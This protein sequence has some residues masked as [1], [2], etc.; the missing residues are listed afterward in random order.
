MY[1]LSP[2]AVLGIVL[3][4]SHCPL[5][6]RCEVK[7]EFL[8]LRW[9]R[10][11]LPLPEDQRISFNETNR[12]MRVSCLNASDRGTYTCQVSNAAGS[13]E[14]HV[15]I[16]PVNS[17]YDPILILYCTGGTLIAILTLCIILFY[18]CKYGCCRTGPTDRRRGQRRTDDIAM[19]E[20][21]YDEPVFRQQEDPDTPRVDPLPYVYTDFIKLKALQAVNNEQ[22]SE[23]F[24]YS[25]IPE[26][27][28]NI[29][30]LQTPT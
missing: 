17:W 14:A 24:G 7:G 30:P 15:N 1:F 9:L 4:T 8:N 29:Q 26:L 21:I 19:E 20:R 16:T 18:I 11:G 23:D 27:Q 3:S 25:T 28:M 12:T 5:T 6:L 22:P 2:P 13:S 10:D